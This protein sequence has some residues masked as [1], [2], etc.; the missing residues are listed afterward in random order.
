MQKP[1]ANSPTILLVDGHSLAFRAY[2]AF[3][4]GREGGLRTST[5]IPTSVS[6]GFLKSLLEVI[7]AEQPSALAIAFDV[8]D[9]TFRHEA[10]ATYKEG[11]P[12]TPE[13]F[14]PDMQN[15]QELLSA[16]NLPLVMA[17]GYEADDVI[18]TLA[19]QA[20][21]GGY[22]VKILSGDRDLFQLVDDHNQVQVLYLSNIYGSA[23]RRGSAPQAFGPAEVKAKLGV[24]PEQVVD[25]KA[26]CGDKSDN[27]PGV[28]GIGEKTAVKL[29]NQFGSLENIYASLDQI[30]GAVHQRLADGKEA[31][32]HSQYLAQIA[33]NVPLT[34][35][36]ADCQLQGFAV[37]SVVP[38]LEKLEFQSFLKQI[39]I[40]R[41]QLGG[42]G[43]AASAPEVVADAAES[44][45]LWFFSSEETDAAQR[46]ESDVL[47][48]E[49]IDTPE[50]LDRLVTL[51]KS[52]TNPNKPVAWDTETDSLSPRDAQLVGLGCCWDVP[53]Q[54]Q[55]AEAPVPGVPS[56]AY[57]PV[58]HRTG[59]NLPL[60]KV[61]EALRPILEDEQ[62]PKA[63]QNAKFDRLVLQFQGIHL[64]GVVFDTMLASYVLNPD[65]SHNLTDLSRQYLSVTA[66]S[67]TDL[68]PKGRTM[69]DVPIPKAAGYCGLDVYTTRLLVEK[70]RKALAQSPQLLALLLE[71]EQPLEPV[72]AAM[73]TRG[74]RIDQDY[75]RS[76]SLQL[77]QDLASLEAQ[78][79]QLAG[80]SF[81]LASP[82]Q[83][84]EILFGKLGLD[85]QKTRP[86]KLGYST[87]AATLEKLQGDH[88][89]VDILLEYRTLA[90]LKSTYVD[91]LPALVRTDTHRV[92]TD[93]N[94][95]ITATGRLSSSNPNLQ[96]IPIR[97]E[98][99]RRI[100]AAFIPE[101][102]WQLVTADYSQIE[103]RI[104]AHLSEEPRLL[105]AYRQGQDVH[106]LTAQLLW[107][108][109]SITS[110]ERRLAK[111]INFGVIYGMG[112]HR[113][114]REAG[115]SYGEAKQFIERFY[116]R[117]PGVF[118][119]L[120][121]MERQAVTQGYVET[122]LGRRRYFQFDSRSL[123][124]YQGQDPED[125]KAVNLNGVKMSAY[126]RG[127][128][129]A[130]A[131]APIQG[132]SADLIKV[133]MVQLYEALRGYRAQLLIQVH[134]ELVLEVP[135]EEL[136]AVQT[137]IQAIMESALSLKVP[138]VAEV[139][140][141]AN[142]MEAK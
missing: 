32:C 69:A 20:R 102:G 107:E 53:N 92:H 130:A 119:Y 37:E 118:A 76:L 12:E 58:G 33:L 16:M 43:V 140:V 1:D 55:G 34:I 21:A 65:A 18:G 81:N 48:P 99:S 57:I 116:E 115:V 56:M 79:H 135:P 141:G 133:A 90:K 134:D 122:L 89:L 124:K 8:G 72:L 112:P 24:T 36:A 82:K 117:Y 13:D 19:H 111:I 80:E 123:K 97:T 49:I 93:F 26:L 94:Q 35:A 106:I 4:K 17:P 59:K 22:R 105:T 9:P 44:D 138:L 113:F 126:D 11:R 25:Y 73:E 54:D 87:D 103:L 63:L 70:L 2:Y 29:L 67:Y 104:L 139:H 47:M 120:Q 61:L 3:A 50:K 114:A 127:L 46:P 77:A 62:Y 38:I 15:L 86:T 98:F 71:V 14:I 95:A 84:S 110:E 88:P 23:A 52:H 137:H 31:A 83:L 66:Q 101:P 131:N 6:Y 121:R 42:A 136:E 91:A 128:L 40:L 129:R 85:T 10:D 60:Q 132:S 64:A 96:N 51:L 74:I 100:R 68:V 39:Q 45:D 78:A 125:M 7:T 109:D 30:T 142:W 27:I 5:G 108:K 28:K 41:Q 75:L